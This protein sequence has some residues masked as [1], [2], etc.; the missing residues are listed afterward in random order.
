[1]VVE[2]QTIPR[3]NEA[4][5]QYTWALT[6]IY[7][8][9]SAWERDVARLD[10]LRGE[11]TALAGT[12]AQGASALLRL[13]QMRDRV[14]MLAQQLYAYANLRRDSDS[15]EPAAQ[16]L[17]A[18]AGSLIAQTMADIAFVEPEILA[19]P[20][21][22]VAA[23]QTQEPALAPYAYYLD[24]LARRRPHV[25]SSE[26]ESVIAQY[27]DIA[28]APGETYA[29]LTETDLT[30]PTIQ[31]EHGKPVQISDSRY[32]VLLSSPDRRVRH[33]AFKAY[34]TTFGGVRTTVAATLAA[35]TRSHVL[36]AR[37]HDYPSAL[38]AALAPNDI[39]LEVYH[40]LIA[41]VDANLPRLHHY[42]SLRKRILRLDELHPYDLNAPLVPDAESVFSYEAARELVIAACAPLGPTYGE[43]LRKALESRWIDVYENV[44]KA[45]GAYSGGAY[46]TAPFILLNYQ[47]RLLDVYTL[48]HELGHSLHSYFSWRAQPFISGD[49]TNFVA[50]VASTLNE[51]L[52][53][54]HLLQT[55]PDVALRKRLIV[56]QLEDIRTTLARQV[57]FAEFELAIHDYTAS[58]A[59]LTADWLGD[60]YRGLVARYHGPEL[61][62]DDEIA[63]EWARIP[64]FYMN[65]YVYQYATG[66]AAAL[67]L[68]AQILSEG[69][70]AVQRYLR[71]LASGDSRPSIEL[72]RQAGVDMASPAPI[73]QAMDRF[74]ALLDELEALSL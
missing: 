26:V 51:L 60:R 3:R 31:D 20:P 17:E 29:A 69:E 45:T 4:P 68:S 57:M 27:G 34:F 25:R 43:A 7:A 62:L 21:E 58:G 9:D 5:V 22:T 49:Y 70:P 37:L 65:F 42:M 39:P 73:Q 72:L 74:A 23:W 63:L 2:T 30:F 33:D 19:L 13:L 67:A 55:S 40:N 32:H 64:H 46:T 59:A 15:T 36:S 10:S 71:L 28:R 18:R 41:T 6:T 24:R 11:A 8:D 16:A 48:A 56:E 14:T 61:T 52:L 1:M 66:L 53:T 44:G 50:E 12:A 54:A 35:T 38:A 47:D